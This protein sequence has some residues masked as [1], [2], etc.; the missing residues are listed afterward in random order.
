MLYLI[1]EQCANITP[2]DARSSFLDDCLDFDIL[3]IK[4]HLE[5]LIDA[6]YLIDIREFRQAYFRKIAALSNS[7]KEEEKEP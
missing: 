4:K 6:A 2:H 7:R 1:Y 3:G 5:K